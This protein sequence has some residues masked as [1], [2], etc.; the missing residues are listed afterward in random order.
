MTYRATKLLLEVLAALACFTTSRSYSAGNRPDTY[1]V[2]MHAKL[3][4][5][6]HN[7]NR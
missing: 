1:A 6:V 3:L 7:V 2:L 5:S 4:H